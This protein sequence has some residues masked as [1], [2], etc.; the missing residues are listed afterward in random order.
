MLPADQIVSLA[1]TTASQDMR[2]AQ[3]RILNVEELMDLPCHRRK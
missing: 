3:G 2:E 1:D